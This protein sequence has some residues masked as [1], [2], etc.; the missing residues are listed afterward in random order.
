VSDD[1]LRGRIDLI[2]QFS[3]DFVPAAGALLAARHREHREAEPLLPKRYENNDAAA[4]EVDALAL[5]GGIRR[6]RPSQRAC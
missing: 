5:D 2:D 1:R 6:G 4:A 3:D